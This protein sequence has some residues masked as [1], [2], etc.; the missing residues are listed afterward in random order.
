M[1]NPLQQLI[2]APLGQTGG[3][4]A[5]LFGLLNSPQGQSLGASQWNALRDQAAYAQ[6]SAGGPQPW[7]GSYYTQPQQVQTPVTLGSGERQNVG[8]D[9]STLQMLLQQ[10]RPNTQPQWHESNAGNDYG[11]NALASSATTGPQL[12]TPQQRMSWLQSQPSLRNSTAPQQSGYYEQLFG[13]DPASDQLRQ[14]KNAEAYVKMQQ[15]QIGIGKGYGEQADDIAKGAGGTPESIINSVAYRDLIRDPQTGLLRQPK[16]G[17]NPDVS[18]YLSHYVETHMDASDPTM[19]ARMVPGHFEGIT[20]NSLQTL[21]FLLN[22]RNQSAANPRQYSMPMGG[23]GPTTQGPMQPQGIQ[24]FSMPQTTAAEFAALHA[25]RPASLPQVAVQ[26][27][28]AS[29]QPTGTAASALAFRNAIPDVIGGVADAGWHA[30]QNA[31]THTANALR[32]A[33]NVAYGL[34]GNDQDYFQQQPA[35]T[36]SLPNPISWFIHRLRGY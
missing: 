10:S 7:Q 31:G 32:T 26:P 14:Q 33:G 20:P 6:N 24:P 9:P 5:Q 16:T 27:D 2:G 34:A 29:V 13:I 36:S 12:D 19:P 8:L 25:A 30:L 4:P 22:A 1:A 28:Q 11:Y 18:G 23:G 3:T 15:D 35:Q 21:Q 17:E